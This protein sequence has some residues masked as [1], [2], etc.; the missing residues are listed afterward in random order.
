M[1]EFIPSP[2]SER[3][4]LRAPSQHKP[5]WGLLVGGLLVRRFLTQNHSSR[6]KPPKFELLSRPHSSLSSIS[7]QLKKEIAS[8]NWEVFFQ[9]FSN[10]SERLTLNI[11]IINNINNK[12]G[13]KFTQLTLLM[14]ADKNAQDFFFIKKK[15]TNTQKHVLNLMYISLLL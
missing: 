11:S 13:I 3:S 5:V 8:D 4:E 7:L 2:R 10:V 9:K 15:Y 14:Y 6:R 12:N 1:R